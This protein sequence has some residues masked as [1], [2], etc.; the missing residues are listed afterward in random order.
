MLQSKRAENLTLPIIF[1]QIANRS[2]SDFDSR[3]EITSAS[4]HRYAI[5]FYQNGIDINAE[6]PFFVV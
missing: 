5:G 4:T 1:A 3:I 2:M 6:N